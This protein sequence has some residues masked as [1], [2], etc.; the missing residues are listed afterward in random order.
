MAEPTERSELPNEL[1]DLLGDR[2]LVIGSSRGP[3]TFLPQSD[4]RLAINRCGG[5]LVTAMM[6][7]AEASAATWVCAASSPHDRA[8][9]EHDPRVALPPGNPSFEM[10]M[11]PIPEDVYD[12][13]YNT[14]ANPLLWFVQ[15]YLW[16]LTREP[17]YD[18]TTL[19][20]WNEGY[21]TFNEAFADAIAEECG[22]A[23]EPL[24]ML[25]DYHLYLCP[26]MLRARGCTAPLTHFTHVPWPGPEYFRVL[27]SY[28]R[29][30]ILEGLLS[31]DIVGFHTQRYVQNFLWT[32]RQVGGYE[33]D[34]EKQQVESASGT[35]TVRAYPISI[36][37]STIRELAAADEVEDRMEALR[38][39]AGD[40]TVIV[41][42]DRAD[43]TKNVLRGFEAYRLMLRKH[44]ELRGKVVFF[45]MLY[46][47][48]TGIEHYRRYL[49]E[50]EDIV[51]R[52]NQ[53]F[54]TEEWRPIRLRIADDYFESLAAMRLCDVL[55]VNPVFDGMNLV[56]KEGPL[57]S[58]RDCVLV[59]SENAGA[60]E[61][62]GGA[63]LAVNPFDCR[64]TAEALYEAITMDKE[65]R[66]ERAAV[67]REI[68]SRN[69]SVKWLYHQL[70]DADE[71]ANAC[72]SR[73]KPTTASGPSTVKSADVTTS[74]AASSEATATENPPTDPPSRSSPNRSNAATSVTSSPRTTA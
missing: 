73:S 43:P 22:S 7:V 52:V 49:A 35:T 11:L 74:S 62:M 29:T 31:A 59:L 32:C 33:V 39:V 72:N 25:Q 14:I 47:T 67:L 20:A 6:C 66:A 50:I 69:D 36:S 65:H 3:Y 24:V 40:A 4:G 16:D 46:A 28:M 71:V 27:P 51:A 68:V 5:G 12:R 30:P 57:I 63:C 8:M 23:P 37:E 26:A 53:E 41:R 56:A 38:E 45:A 64:Q 19:A 44:P 58:D 70:R 15:H 1:A 34:F 2:R 18:D 17:S 55:L 61:E 60:Y 48:R 10:R 13:Y 9:A 54:G 42:A 21:V